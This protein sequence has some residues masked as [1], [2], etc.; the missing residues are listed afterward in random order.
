MIFLYD[1]SGSNWIHPNMTQGLHGKIELV[2]FIDK[3]EKDD[4]VF[5]GRFSGQH[6]RWV[7][8]MRNGLLM[9]NLE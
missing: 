1:F 7:Q 5:F 8:T 2:I 3:N 9:C 6:Y 4:G